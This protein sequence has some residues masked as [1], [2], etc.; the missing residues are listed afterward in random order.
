MRDEISD[1]SEEDDG[2]SKRP[3]D[4]SFL[5]AEPVPEPVSAGEIGGEARNTAGGATHG[6]F[7][8]ERPLNVAAATLEFVFAQ[9]SK[10]VIIVSKLPSTVAAALPDA[11]VKHEADSRAREQAVR[12][13][14]DLAAKLRICHSIARDHAAF[15]RCALRRACRAHPLAASC[16]FAGATQVALER[17]G[18]LHCVDGR[19]FHYA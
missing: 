9:L 4:E 17:C 5:R 19:R 11:F 14:P 12:A 15:K 18:E 2:R 10:L 6:A 8:L 16:V 3:R 7:T 13:E 1:Q